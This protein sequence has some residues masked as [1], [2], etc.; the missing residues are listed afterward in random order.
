MSDDKISAAKAITS[1]SQSI[2]RQRIQIQMAKMVSQT[3]EQIASEQNFEK[4]CDAGDFN[5]GILTKNFRTLDELK[6]KRKDK[7]EAQNPEEVAEEEETIEKI[8]EVE[9]TFETEE[10]LQKDYPELSLRTL[11]ALRESLLEADTPET[12]LRKVLDFYPDFTIAD[13]ALDLLLQTTQGDLASNVYLAKELLNT[14]HGRE[15]KAGKN[16]AQEVKEFSEKGLGTP[17][18]LR[19]MYRDITANPRTPLFLFDQLSKKYPYSQ[20]KKISHFLLHALGSDLKSKGSSISKPE[21]TRHLEDVK[22]LQAILGVFRFFQSRMLLIQKQFV[23][24]QIKL[25]FQVTFETLSKLFISLFGERYINSEKI[26]SL[27]QSLGITEEIAAQI[28]LI[29][30]MRDAIRQVSPRLYKNDQQK[31]DLLSAI[32]EALEELEEKYEEKEE[33]EKPKKEKRKKQ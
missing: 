5:L 32:L 18:A 24:Y 15:V 25:P 27:S 16:I 2:Q 4:W 13:E 26:L 12:I 7:A 1:A 17:N 9:K 30:Q 14:R 33:E 22:S 21:L 10:Q 8:K 31:Q 23:Q 11:K 29:T 3:I 20:L 28:I 19:D 6:V